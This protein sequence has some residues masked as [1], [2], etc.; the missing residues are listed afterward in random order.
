[1]RRFCE[2]LPEDRLL[3]G[4]Q[5]DVNDLLERDSKKRTYTIS[6]TGASLTYRSALSVLARYASSLVST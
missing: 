5:R 6:S 2:E 3:D 4:N 1:M